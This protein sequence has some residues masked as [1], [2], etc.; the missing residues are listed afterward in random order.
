MELKDASLFKDFYLTATQ[1]RKLEYFLPKNISLSLPSK[2]SS[3]PS[4]QIRKIAPIS[5]SIT[6][7][8]PHPPP[9]PPA[10]SVY[11]PPPIPP[12]PTIS[13][14]VPPSPPPSTQ[15]A[16]QSTIQPQVTTPITTVSIQPPQA[17][18]P[19][20]GTKV[21][22]RE[23]ISMIN[24]LKKFDKIKPFL[25]P[26]DPILLNIPDYF[27]IITRPMDISTIEAKARD[28]QYET[29]EQ[30]EADVKLIVANAVRYNPP[31]NIVHTMAVELGQFFDQQI[32][33][34]EQM[35][36]PVKLQKLQQVD[37][38]LKKI[39]SKKT[40]IASDETPLT[41]NEKIALVDMI[42]NKLPQ[43]CMWDILCIVAPGKTDVEEI[44]FD[45]DKLPTKTSKELQAYVLGQI[46][47]R[48]KKKKEEPFKEDVKEPSMALTAS[49]V[50][51]SSEKP[52]LNR[53]HS[54][55]SNWATSG[56]EF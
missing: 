5:V 29:F 45:L 17:S 31:D 33:L 2:L 20:S 13:S 27:L 34:R 23:I 8:H 9:P 41:Y 53:R 28:G 32:K 42:K 48:S 16:I 40:K 4:I 24:K 10:P 52:Q 47:Q 1:F 37:S 11:V 30:F 35:S 3:R 19:S 15:I 54:S 51:Q 36:D 56:D 12:Q 46:R 55:S 50:P 22:P 26:V 6:V 21:R 43:E 49:N 44:D 25:E 39:E 14:Y 18:A 38:R 7:P